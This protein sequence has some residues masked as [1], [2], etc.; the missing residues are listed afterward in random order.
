MTLLRD[1]VSRSPFRSAQV[2]ELV[3]QEEVAA[4]V[5]A[6]AVEKAVVEA[7]ESPAG[8]PVLFRSEEK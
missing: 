6:L 7:A 4:V 5:E 1:Q 3:S 8:D 2:S